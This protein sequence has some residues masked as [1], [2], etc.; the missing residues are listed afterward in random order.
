MNENFYD[1]EIVPKLMA[2]AKICKSKG[3]PF[4]AVIEY[5]SGMIGKTQVQT[6]SECIEMI[7]IRHCA[8]TAP[9]VD[10]FIIGLMR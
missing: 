10:G 1:K 2:V 3:I 4:L 9:N 8:K 5:S 6:N 7:M